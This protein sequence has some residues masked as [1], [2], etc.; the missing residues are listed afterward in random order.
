MIRDIYVA[1]FKI[2]KL[3]QFKTLFT[4]PH[5]FQRIK[6]D[7]AYSKTWIL[8]PFLNGLTTYILIVLSR[9]VLVT[10]Q[11]KIGDKSES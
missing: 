1:S 9:T 2:V 5:M 11:C 6:S 7:G 4:P 3:K 10:D 8:T